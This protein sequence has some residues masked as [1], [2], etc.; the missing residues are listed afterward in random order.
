MFKKP[1]QSNQ[2]NSESTG[3]GGLIGDIVKP[4]VDFAGWRAPQ[5]DEC[6]YTKGGCH[7]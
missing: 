7:S 1:Q 5:R 3:E 6:L 4:L 2:K